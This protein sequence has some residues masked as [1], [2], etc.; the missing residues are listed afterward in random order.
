MEATAYLI[1]HVNVNLLQSMSTAKLINFVMDLII[2]PCLVIVNTIIK[3]SL[4]HVFFT[5]SI[6]NLLELQGYCNISNS[7]KPTEKK[8]LFFLYLYFIEADHDATL[9]ATWNIPYLQAKT[10]HK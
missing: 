4:V 8:L 5:E 9:S 2:Y 3:Q 10:M 6:D 1:K 7:S